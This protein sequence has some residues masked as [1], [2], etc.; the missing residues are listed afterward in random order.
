MSFPVYNRGLV[1][2]KVSDQYEWG[3]TTTTPG[4]F[5]AQMLAL[6]RL[7]FSFSRIRDYQATDQAVLVT[8][9]DGYSSIMEF[10]AP[11]LEEVGGVATVFAISDYVGRKNSW[12]YF[13][14][15]KQ[16]DHMPWADLRQL[17]DRGWE[18]GSH[19]RSHRRLIGLG[20]D[21][22]RDELLVSK[23]EIEDQ[24]GEE[25][26]TFCPPFNAWNSDLLSQ[27][28]D[29]GYT[30]IAISYPL[31]G[32][33]SWAGEFIPRLGV[34]LHDVMPLFLAKI[35]AS[36]LAPIEVLQQQLI[37]LA[38]DGKILE[39]WLKPPAK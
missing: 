38:G 35:L 36:P 23:R 9:D 15:H 32:L 2:H 6:K 30:K 22:V 21:Q 19:G 7:G 13:P 25:V 29:A 20:Q 8:F 28:E 39:N 27:I 12:D 10:A 17:S 24:V 18:I 4:Q 5:K 1:Y 37:N 26:T 31:T 33:P 11:I 3:V 34:Y 16:V 14:E